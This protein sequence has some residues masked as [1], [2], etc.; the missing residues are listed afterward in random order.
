MTRAHWE[1][2][3]RGVYVLFATSDGNGGGEVSAIFVPSGVPPS[4][5]SSCSQTPHACPCFSL[6]RFNRQQY[7]QFTLSRLSSPARVR[8][9]G[10]SPSALW[11]MYRHTLFSSGRS[12]LSTCWNQ[13]R[14][15][16]SE[17]SSRRRPTVGVSLTQSSPWVSSRTASR[18]V[19]RRKVVW[20]GGGGGGGGFVFF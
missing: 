14:T 1:D 5:S 20:G 16:S 6:T 7:S 8:P 18:F 4:S 2:R 12:S 17:A 9:L 13:S 15:P 3:E 19:V 10:S 11:S